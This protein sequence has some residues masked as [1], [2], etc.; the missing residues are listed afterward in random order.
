MGM[1]LAR[2]PHAEEVLAAH[3]RHLKRLGPSPSRCC[4]PHSSPGTSA[5]TATDPRSHPSVGGSPIGTATW[6]SSGRRA[7]ARQ[8]GTP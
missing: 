8:Q 2:C 1:T 4:S 5:S 7:G 3:L 6:H